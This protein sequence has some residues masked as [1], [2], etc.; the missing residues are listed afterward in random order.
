MRPLRQFGTLLKDLF[1][2]KKSE[3]FW[4]RVKE[5]VISKKEKENQIFAIVELLDKRIKINGKNTEY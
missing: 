1:I 4:V 2:S 3:H 5:Q